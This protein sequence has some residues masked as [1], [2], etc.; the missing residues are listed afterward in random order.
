MNHFVLGARYS[1]P[2]KHV[3]LRRPLSQTLHLVSSRRHRRL[4]HH[5]ATQSRRTKYTTN[6]KNTN[7]TVTSRSKRAFQ[8]T[9]NSLTPASPFPASGKA[10]GTRCCS[11]NPRT[12]GG[13]GSDKGRMRKNEQGVRGFQLHGGTMASRKDGETRLS[14]AKG[15]TGKEEALTSGMPA[16]VRVLSGSLQHAWHHTCVS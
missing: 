16:H 4:I 12:C 8:Q 13:H 11:R 2:W 7:T 6:R 5:H 15:F 10:D 3:N 14:M 1:Q 9:Y